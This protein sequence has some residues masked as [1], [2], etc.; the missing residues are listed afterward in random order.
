MDYLLYLFR[1]LW[2]R[3]SLS[4]IVTSA[5]VRATTNTNIIKSK[6]FTAPITTKYII[7]RCLW[8][9]PSRYIRKT[10]IRNLYPIACFARRSAIKIIL[11]NINPVSLDIR[12][13]D[14]RVRDVDHAPCGVVIRFDSQPISR[15][16]D[17]GVRE[18]QTLR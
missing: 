8:D 15:I 18:P 17:D 12:E 10:D 16:C 6:I 14:I 13:L 9:H 11:L 3:A 5:R 7:V 2:P 4:W 1:R